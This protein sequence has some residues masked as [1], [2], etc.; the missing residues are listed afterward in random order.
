MKPG[1]IPT[2]AACALALTLQGCATS[3]DKEKA[4][5]EGGDTSAN[6]SVDCDVVFHCP[7]DPTDVT[8]CR[9]ADQLQVLWQ[10]PG[11]DAY[12]LS[13]Q[14]GQTFRADY[15]Q[16]EGVIENTLTWQHMGIRYTAF[17]Y[18]DESRPETL[19]EIG[20]TQETQGQS[21]RLA[22]NGNAISR[23]SALHDPAPGQVD[24]A[25]TTG[26]E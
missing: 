23:L 24:N 26:E 8:I 14:L 7:A 2:L 4:E 12:R 16:Y 9:D 19:E 1:L 15:S 17:H 11:I 10:T 21:R 3:D 6:T 18:L 25:P 5:A 20:I 22:C 13:G